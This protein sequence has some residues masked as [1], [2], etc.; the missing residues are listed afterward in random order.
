[1]LNIKTDSRLVSNGDVFVAIKGHTVDGHDY[2]EQAIKNGASKIV[3][4]YGSFSIDTLIVEDTEKWL[5]NYLVENYSDK[6]K[7]IKFIGI[8]GTNGKTT[9]AYL[10]SQILT[11]LN[12]NNAYIGTIGYYVNSELLGEAIA[13]DE[14]YKQQNRKGCVTLPYVAIKKV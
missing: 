4:E 1:M 8:T 2:I 5:N 11:K 14:I 9:T 6:F 3:A 10:T 7:D 13:F 12:I